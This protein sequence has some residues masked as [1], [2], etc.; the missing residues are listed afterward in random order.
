[1]IKDG[2]AR[3]PCGVAGEA[4]QTAPFKKKTLNKNTERDKSTRPIGGEIQIGLPST[5]RSWH[6]VGRMAWSLWL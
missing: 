6:A 3:D 4:R 2:G 5:D 1:M